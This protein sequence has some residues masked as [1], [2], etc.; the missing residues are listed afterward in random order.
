LLTEYLLILDDKAG[1]GL[2]S[3]PLKR[4]NEHPLVI[5]TKKLKKN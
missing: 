1:E 5:E 4:E 2:F 3:G